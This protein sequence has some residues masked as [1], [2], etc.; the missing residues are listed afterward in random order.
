MLSTGWL[1]LVFAIIG[2][3]NISDANYK[4]VHKKVIQKGYG[5]V[6]AYFAATEKKSGDLQVNLSTTYAE[7]F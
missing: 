2:I 5:G 4:A 6:K 3:T 7:T 1:L